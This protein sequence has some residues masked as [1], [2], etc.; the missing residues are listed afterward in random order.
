MT[1]TFSAESHAPLGA[2]GPLEG[3]PNARSA[4]Y[5]VIVII[6][7]P[8]QSTCIEKINKYN[9]TTIIDNFNQANNQNYFAWSI[10]V[11]N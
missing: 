4:Q 1:N 11:L 8:F 7:I 2:E 5:I 10:I 3:E 9:N 6:T